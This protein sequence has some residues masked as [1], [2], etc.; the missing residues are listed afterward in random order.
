MRTAPGPATFV[1]SFDCEGKWGVADHLTPAL[2]AQ[3]RNDALNNVYRQLL[4][5]LA[6]YKL[7]A[8]F[9]FVASHTLSPAEFRA[10]PELF[11]SLAGPAQSWLT[12]IQQALARGELDG[13][14]NPEAVAMV[15][16]AGQH[17]IASHSHRHIPGQLLNETQFAGELALAD[18]VAALK[19]L[20]WPTFV[21]PR[22]QICFPAQLAAAGILA[23]RDRPA[24]GHSRPQNLLQEFNLW[25]AG[26]ATVSG[27]PVCLP[28]GHLLNWR[29]GPRRLVPPAVTV[30]RWRNMLATASAHG[31]VVHLW[32]HP[33]N[34]LTGRRQFDLL[35]RIL[36]LVTEA[37]ATGRLQPLTQHGLAVKTASLV[38]K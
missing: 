11:P 22:N 23:Y 6:H 1:L 32:S 2:S 13:W 27:E 18:E 34:F 4:A 20:R 15:A 12:P 31:Q 29:A 24:Y 3:L 28:A 37:R 21:Y 17:E 5:M 9:A 38:A 8:T 30:R 33:H 35:T 19:G 14:L 10:H 25:A 26:E 16:A 7:P 36:R